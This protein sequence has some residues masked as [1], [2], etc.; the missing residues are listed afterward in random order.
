M[1]KHMEKERVHSRGPRPASFSGGRFNRAI[2]PGTRGNTEQ[3]PPPHL[4]L[5]SALLLVWL[6]VAKR[7]F[8][9][10]CL[11]PSSTC[12]EWHITKLFD[13]EQQIF[14]FFF[15]SN[16]D[17]W[18]WSICE[19]AWSCHV[20]IRSWSSFLWWDFIYFFSARTGFNCFAIK[21]YQRIF[22]L[23]CIMYF[24][25]TTI[26][27]LLLHFCRRRH[28]NTYVYSAISITSNQS[29]LIFFPS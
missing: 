11:C 2:T 8:F 12:S 19:S 17:S 7:P 5:F 24:F 1:G 18:I 22:F 25:W 27:L 23:M 16:G 9:L 4:S 26:S 10:L 14:F 15:F 28:P 29:P 13:F 6:E 3:L 20:Y 21:K